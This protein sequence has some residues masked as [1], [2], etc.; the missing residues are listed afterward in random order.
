MKTHLDLLRAMRGLRLAD[1]EI[2]FC[3]ADDGA[4]WVKAQGKM[5][6]HILSINKRVNPVDMDQLL[7]YADNRVVFEEIRKAFVRGIESLSGQTEKARLT[8][9]EPCRNCGYSRVLGKVSD[10]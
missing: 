6:D 1:S 5:G 3:I 9:I 2:R 7:D 10:S 4:L 8:C